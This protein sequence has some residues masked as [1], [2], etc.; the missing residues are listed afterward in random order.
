M[1]F[2]LR[3]LALFVLGFVVGW[4]GLN[5]W[6]KFKRRQD[7]PTPPA[8][9]TKTQSA[10]APTPPT[11]NS[12]RFREAV[13]AV[14]ELNR[15]V[16]LDPAH[17]EVQ[18]MLIETIVDDGLETLLLAHERQPNH[19]LSWEMCR[20]LSHWLPKHVQGYAKLSPQQRTSQEGQYQEGLDRM[21]S[22]LDEFR[23]ILNGGAE[24]DFSAALATIRLKFN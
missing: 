4:I 8:Q 14:I 18:V 12:L 23:Q 15:S 19:E 17:S 13:S 5:L 22:Q 20:L 16:R 10:P 6:R 21:K 11:D 7:E 1:D 9:S 24:M 2:G 3:Q